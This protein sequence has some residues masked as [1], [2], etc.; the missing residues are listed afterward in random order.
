MANNTN[1]KNAQFST[2]RSK[3]L[4]SLYSDEP[5]SKRKRNAS[6]TY[7]SV[8]YSTAEQVR[9]AL[10]NA[11]ADKKSIIE[12]SKQLFVTNPIYASI[13]NYLTNMYM[14]KT[15]VIPHRIYTQSKAIGAKMIDNDDYTVLYNLMLEIMEGLSLKTKIPLLLQ[16][17]FVEGS[18]FFTTVSDEDS[19][20]VDT[21]ILPTNYCR[22]VA[23]TQFGTAIVEFDMSYF[24]TLGLSEADLKTYLKSFPKEF[25]KGYH[26][27]QRNSQERWCQLDPRFSSGVMMNELGIPTYIYLL[28][29]IINF[30]K[31]QDN[32]LERN[33]NALKYLVV[34]T[35][36]HYEDQLI[37]EVDEVKA[38]HDSLKKIVDTG[39]KARLITTYGD[40]KVEKIGDNDTVENQVLSKAFNAIF[41]NAGFNSA[42]FTSN[43]VQALK[44]SLVR[45][46]GTVWR[47]A[48][49]FISFYNIAI[50]NWFDFRGYQA[51]IDL[52]PISAYTYDDDIEVFKNNA[53][54]GVN[55]IDYLIA[56][57]IEQK[58]ISDVLAL[59][60][61]L[62]LD[63]ITP[64]QTSYTQTAE[65]RATI[66]A[67]NSDEE[68]T[69]T[70]ESESG[71]E[72]SESGAAATV[73][74]KEEKQSNT[75][76]NEDTK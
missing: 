14:W 17:L 35:I 46:K 47:F 19:L 30:E 60:K 33:D 10:N 26:N 28:G 70:A 43:S 24:S 22:K 56:S 9:K 73:A 50:N 37:F 32:E 25:E 20:T 8:N 61:T 62:G 76:A 38:L 64:M 6:T 40:I 11:T 58:N 13:I 4:A 51:D 65:D 18:V 16:K 31:Y 54:L 63:G 39:D 52:L 12:T 57:G 34:Q 53:T 41:N 1:D 68:T 71:I 49:Q 69:S 29:S 36:P 5:S 27:Y 42:L 44:M 59:E 2:S 74:S 15:K 67:S 45:D 48:Q 72:P 7:S 55:K 3:Q 66:D 23:E 21:L 75:N